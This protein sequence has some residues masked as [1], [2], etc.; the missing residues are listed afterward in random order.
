[1]RLEQGSIC[2]YCKREMKPHEKVQV[3]YSTTCDDKSLKVVS[4]AK[5][6]SVTALDLCQ[7]CAVEFSLKAERKVFYKRKN[8]LRNLFEKHNAEVRMQKVGV[9]NA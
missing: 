4:S 8:P 2:D 1:M 5:M 7:E 9:S 3:R 6:Q